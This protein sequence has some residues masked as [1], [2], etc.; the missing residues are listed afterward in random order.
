MA[1]D[2]LDNMMA[3]ECGELDD[4]ET[5][6]LFAELV[7]NG[8]AWSLQGCYGEQAARLIEAGYISESGDI[9]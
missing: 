3:W 9:L 1:H 6:K 4:E 5:I 8:R 2:L 7:R